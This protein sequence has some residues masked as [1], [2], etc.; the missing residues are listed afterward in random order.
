MRQKLKICTIG[1]GSSYTPELVEGFIKRQKTFPVTDIW[2]SDIKE[3]E[4]KLKIVGSLAKRMV[5][6]AGVPIKIHLTL[7]LEEALKDADF[8]TTQIRVGF[9]AARELDETIPLRHG[10]IGQ[11]TNGAGGLFKALRTVP[12]ILDI[13]SKMEKL[14]P[15]AFLINFTNPSG[16]ITEALV[17][18][19]KLDKRKVI[20][21]CNVP[22][23]IERT[24]AQIFGVEPSRVRVDFAG[25]NHLVYGLHVY[26]DGVDFTQKTIDVLLDPEKNKDLSVKNV[27]SISYTKEFYKTLGVICCPYHNYYYHTSTMLKNELEEFEKGNIR[28]QAVQ[29][30]EKKLFEIYADKNLDIKPQEL[31]QRGGAFYSEAACRLINSLYNDTRDI[32]P[33]DTVN[34]GAIENIDDDS[35][36]EVS[37]VITKQGPFPLQMGKLPIAVNGLVSQIKSFERLTV[38]AAVE[39]SYEKAVLALAINPLTPNEAVAKKIVDEL[40]VAHKKY[41]PQFQSYFKQK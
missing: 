18:Y 30:I 12:V 33:V 31:S 25:L 5:E 29:K 17:R 21:L 24:I 22:I 7:N 4:K 9:L 1:G 41:L 8:V 16:I 36:V 35:V 3:G 40:M 28:S 27:M 6:K 14:C 23:H 10:V 32:Q 15:N 26:V 39:G 13:A 2:L 11:E 37:S 19:G 38:E 34:N 20:G